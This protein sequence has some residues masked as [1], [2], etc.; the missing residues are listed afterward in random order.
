MFGVTILGNNSA[1]PMHDRHPTAQ[2]V[3]F[4]EMGFL[5]DCGEGTQIQ[6]NKYKIRRS[7]INHIFISHLHGDHYFGLPGLLNSY[8]L[9][10]RVEA[11]HLYAPP[12]LES[13]LQKIFEISES[14]LSYPFHFHPLIENGVI[15][16]EKKLTVECFAV[17]H[18]IPCWGFLFKEKPKPRK[19]DAE[20]AKQQSIPAS[21]YN[22]LKQGEDYLRPDGILIKNAEVTIDPIPS[23]SYAFCADTLYVPELKNIIRNVNLMYH[24]TTYLND[25]KEKAKSRYHSTTDEAAGLASDASAERL[26]VGHFSSKY[27]D[28][29]PFLDETRRI[30]SNTDL[31]LEGV[32]YLIPSKKSI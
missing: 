2:V 6:M 22:K 29:T 4:D 23:R 26:L 20:L 32:T 14:E 31:A 15:L 1:L 7:K 19:I 16:D 18:R 27:S 28:L 11:L 30:F 3:T 8:S 13:L 12:E 25:Q 21:F 24:E 10:G 5:I 9:T 17:E